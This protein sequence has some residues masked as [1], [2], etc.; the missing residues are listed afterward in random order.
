[1]DLRGQVRDVT[2]RA[3]ESARVPSGFVV[4]VSRAAAWP[5][6]STQW[7]DARTV[8]GPGFHAFACPTATTPEA[9][10]EPQP[11]VC[12][13]FVVAYRGRVD[14]RTEL[15]ARLGDRDLATAPDGAVLRAAFVRWGAELS[16]H[17]IG[18]YAYAIIDRSAAT[19][20]AAADG[21]G[22]KRVLVVEQPRCV[23]LA[24]DIELLL[25]AMPE[26]P[27]LDPTAL[28]EFLA[29]GTMLRHQTVYR[30][31]RPIRAGHVYEQ[32]GERRS[33][34][35]AWWPDRGRQRGY[36]G[37]AER[38]ASLRGLL[39]EAVGAA[40][41]SSG[42][43]WSD[44]SGG[45]DSSTVTSIAASLRRSTPSRL[46]PVSAFSIVFSRTV[47]SDESA[48]Q[49]QV[50]ATHDLDHVLLDGDTCPEY[51]ELDTRHPWE[52]TGMFLRGSVTR[53][54]RELARAANV[55]VNL[56]G[57]GGDELFGVAGYPPV[58]LA[59]WL[60]DGQWRLLA[61]QLAGYVARGELSLSS[62]VWDFT[63]RAQSRPRPPRNR[64]P[65][66]AWAAKSL[67][68]RILVGPSDAGEER[69]FDSP[70]RQ[71][72]Y[73]MLA[74]GIPTLH[75]TEILDDER[76]PLLYRPLVESM[77]AAPW[78]DKIT[79]DDDR[80]LMRRALAGVV[81]DSVRLRRSKAT[82]TPAR[83][84]GLRGHWDRVQPLIEGHHLDR[85]GLVDRAAFKSACQRYR[86]GVIGRD[87]PFLTA[88]LN[89]EAWLGSVE[90]GSLA[91][92]V[93]ELGPLRDAFAAGPRPFAE[94][95][96]PRMEAS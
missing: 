13:R 85:C 42:P 60:R 50:V 87:L 41:R 82:A 57:C 44:L 90:D 31:V 66:V 36:T 4:R 84:P 61:R 30:G 40:L 17:V 93:A 70:A 20:V 11:I 22:L 39:D 55:R 27:R 25:A 75:V 9:V 79:P 92:R 37:I 58:H 15:A 5:R 72:Q 10:D 89:L 52:P 24:S 32:R 86:H 7:I 23:W 71:Y 21:L 59:E 67:R 69:L 83:F 6:G 76:H 12:D 56:T 78:E 1:M 35:R 2:G 14:N 34:R 96:E 49:R 48:F 81:P 53:A 64:Q 80:A 47:T 16:A 94:I 46:P 28:A 3:G 18:E 38:A 65:D 95:A 77:L 51:A 88:A 33:E 8:R 73:E 26:Q 29:R 43:V 54:I 62:L 74:A 19:V 45:L 68:T 63:L 91:R